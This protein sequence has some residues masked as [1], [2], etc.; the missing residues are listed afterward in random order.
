MNLDNAIRWIFPG[1][2]LTAILVEVISGPLLLGVLRQRVSVDATVQ[3][4]G[5]EPITLL[6]GI[7][8]VASAFHERSSLATLL[9]AGAGLYIVYT[10]VTVVF[11][12]DYHRYDGN[13]ERWF[14][15]FVVITLTTIPVVA[16]KFS[17]LLRAPVPELGWLHRGT[18]LIIGLLFAILWI[19]AIAKER[20]AHPPEYLAD[21][22]LFWLIKFLDLAVVVPTAMICATQWTGSYRTG[23]LLVLTF[24]VWILWGIAGMQIS[25]A[26][27]SQ[28][29]VGA[30]I[31]ALAMILGGLWSMSCLWMASI[32]GSL[33]SCSGCRPE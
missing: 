19:S 32:P 15:L 28:W 27:A 21:P 31:L 7:V 10:M 25:T 1:V 2:A 29:P 9:G 17:L 11:G 12:Q 26:A 4:L 20:Q 8:L 33:G 13:A 23:G 3:Y 6:A 24:T 16:R 22:T 5:S 30:L 14:F 18:L